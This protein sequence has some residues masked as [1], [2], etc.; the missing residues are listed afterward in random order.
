M[1]AGEGERKSIPVG[2]ETQDFFPTETK[3][4]TGMS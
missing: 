4:I 2:S 1:G 3:A